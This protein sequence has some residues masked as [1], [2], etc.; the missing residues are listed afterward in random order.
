[1]S[2]PAP[3]IDTAAACM[4]AGNKPNFNISREDPYLPSISRLPYY[5]AVMRDHYWSK[6]KTSQGHLYLYWSIKGS[7]GYKLIPLHKKTCMSCDPKFRTNNSAC[8]EMFCNCASHRFIHNM[9]TLFL[10]ED[11]IQPEQSLA[12]DSFVVCCRSHVIHHSQPWGT[13]K[14]S[15]TTFR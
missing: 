13:D 5:T 14:G 12:F 6:N 15:G 7:K 8:M 4:S 3:V 9:P 11:S 1:M 10:H 2:F